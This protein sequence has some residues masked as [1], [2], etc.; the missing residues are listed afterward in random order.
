MD[1]IILQFRPELKNVKKSIQRAEALLEDITGKCDMIVMP[2]MAL[3]GY[4]FSS[5]EDIAPFVEPLA[6]TMAEVTDKMSTLNWC[7]D[8]STRFSTWVACGMAEVDG[9][10]YYNT[11]ILVNAGLGKIHKAR[12]VFLYDDDKLWA[13]ESDE[14]FKA[15]DILINSVGREVRVGLGTC[16]DINWKDFEGGQERNFELAKF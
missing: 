9:D 5:R 8:V 1:T 11:L 6:A 2:E 10:T 12:K 4:K 13:S 3:I 16:M 15:F 7:L 14:Y